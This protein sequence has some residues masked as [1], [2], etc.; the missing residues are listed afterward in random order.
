MIMQKSTKNNKY[1]YNVGDYAFI[2]TDYKEIIE[3]EVIKRLKRPYR[4][5]DNFYYCLWVYNGREKRGVRYEAEMYKDIDSAMM[6][7]KNRDVL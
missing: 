5:S 1:K 7:L 3:V 6:V 4:L 2:V